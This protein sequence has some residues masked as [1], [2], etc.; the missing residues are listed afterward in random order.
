MGPREGQKLYEHSV[1]D[2]GNLL[3]KYRTLARL[4]G[5]ASS[6]LEKIKP[7]VYNKMSHVLFPTFFIVRNNKLYILRVNRFVHR[8]LNTFI[9]IKD[10][11][12]VALKSLERNGGICGL[13]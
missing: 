1:V 11:V 5:L 10:L 3:F 7:F 2:A 6:N 12:K 4:C 8:L 13:M 9:A